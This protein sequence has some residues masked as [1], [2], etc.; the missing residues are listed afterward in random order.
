MEHLEQDNSVLLRGTP[1]GEARYSHAS[2]AARFY[3]LPLEVRRLSGTADRLNVTLRESM[4]DDVSGCRRLC[5]AGELRTFNNR[6]GEWPRLVISVF[7]RRILPEDGEDENLVLLRGTLCRRPNPRLTPMGREICDLLLA[8]N[9]RYGRSDYL[10]CICWG[11]VAREAQSWDVGTRLALR[12]RIQSRRYLKQTE[13]GAEERTA[14]EVSV[15]EAEELEKG[16][17]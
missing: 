14:F 16:L 8:V 9:R 3:T 5:V 13:T 1:M 10:P 11:S 12:G 2:R 6:A 7:A 15:A 17:L 4:L